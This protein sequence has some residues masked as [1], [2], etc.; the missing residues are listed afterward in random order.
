M[1]LPSSIA[2]STTETIGLFR[3]DANQLAAWLVTMLGEKWSLRPGGWDS[4]E[5]L[6]AFLDPRGPK[7][8]YVLLPWGGWTV[9]LTDGPLGTDPGLFPSRA[10]SRYGCTAIRATAAEPSPDRFGAV[11][12]EVF[13]PSSTDG[14]ARCRRAI[15]AAD[16]GGRWVF[17]DEGT[18]FDFEDLSAYG[19]R[20]IRDRFTP[21]MLRGYL[22]E[23]GVPVDHDIDLANAQVIERRRRPRSVDAL[24]HLLARR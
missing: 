15:A 6:G 14:L 16:D 24:R 23:L 12:L 21:A 13:D 17:I 19:R 1:S 8:R 10:A 18:P 4:I 3:C 22:H 11:I 20:R 5:A 9:M 7:S 2:G